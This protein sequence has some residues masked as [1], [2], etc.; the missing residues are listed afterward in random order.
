MKKIHSVN[1][2][3][4]TKFLVSELKKITKVNES[5]QVQFE[6]FYFLNSVSGGN[7]I[8][9]LNELKQ[10]SKNDSFVDSLKQ[11]IDFFNAKKIPFP[12]WTYGIF[13]CLKVL[14]IASDSVNYID[15]LSLEYSNL[16]KQ[17]SSVS[18]SKGGYFYSPNDLQVQNNVLIKYSGSSPIF[19]IPRFIDTIGDDAFKDNHHLTKVI[20][21]SH[22]KEIGKFAF[23]NCKALKTIKI[24]DLITT[25]QKGTFQGCSLLAKV[26]AKKI[27]TIEDHAFYETAIEAQPL[28]MLNLKNIGSYAFGKTQTK[29]RILL[30]PSIQRIGQY[31]FEQCFQVNE[32]SILSQNIQLLRFSNLFDKPEEFNAKY[33]VSTIELA[34]TRYPDGF[35]SNLQKIVSIALPNLTELSEGLFENNT[36]LISVTLPNKIDVIPDRLFKN[37]IKLSKIVVNDLIL[38]RIGTSAFE[39]CSSLKSIP[40]LSVEIIQDR[41]FYGSAI[42]NIDSFISSAKSLGD[43]CIGAIKF[44][45]LNLPFVGSKEKEQDPIKNKFGYIFSKSEFPQ[46]IDFIQHLNLNQK[47]S[48]KRFI[49]KGLN[50]ISFKI[51][52]L[53]EFSCSNIPE[54]SVFRL[55]ETT[56]NLPDFTFYQCPDL[57]EF[58]IPK[59]C[60]FFDGKVVD[61][62]PKLSI[63]SCDPSSKK[64]IS[65]DGVLF[66]K[67]MTELIF[68]PFNYSEKIFRVPPTVM[69]IKSRAFSRVRSLE[70]IILDSSVEVIE[71]EAIYHCEKLARIKLPS[72]IKIIAENAISFC[73]ELTTVNLYS[74]SFF[75]QSGIIIGCQQ[76]K[77]LHV[78]FQNTNNADFKFFRIFSKTKSD[79]TYEFNGHYIPLS[80]TQLIVLEGI[81]GAFAFEGM[82][83]IQNVE[84]KDKVKTIEPFAFKGILLDSLVIPDSVKS[85]NEKAF[86]DLKVKTLS[87]PYLG[88]DDQQP[89]PLSSI[90][91]F[92]DL[93]TISIRSGI[94][95]D[96][97]FSSFSSLQQIEIQ[98]VTT[99]RQQVFLGCLNIKKILIPKSVTKIERGAFEGSSIDILAVEDQHPIYQ[100]VDQTLV[101]NRTLIYY[102]PNKKDSIYNVPLTIDVI[103]K[104]S[105]QNNQHLKKIVF[106]NHVKQVEPQA[107]MDCI[108]LE[109]IELL[110]DKVSTISSYFKGTLPKIKSIKVLSSVIPHSA[111]AGLITLQK[112]EFGSKLEIIGDFAFADC[113][114]LLIIKIPETVTLIGDFAFKNCK[115]ITTIFVPDSVEKI[116]FG[117]FSGCVHLNTLTLPMRPKYVA[118]EL[119]MYGGTFGSLFGTFEYEHGR[120]VEQK[121]NHTTKRTYY[122]PK[123]LTAVRVTGGMMALG[124]FSGMSF[125][126]ELLVE[127]IQGDIGA[128]AFESCFALKSIVLNPSTKTIGKEAFKDCQELFNF[129]SGD[130]LCVIETGAFSGCQKLTKI[131]FGKGLSSIETNIFEDCDSLSEI[132]FTQGNPR[133]R[134][135]DGCLMDETEKSVILNPTKNPNEIVNIPETIETISSRAF[136]QSEKLREVNFSKNLKNIGNESFYS[137]KKLQEVNLQVCDQLTKIGQEAFAYCTSLKTINFNDQLQVIEPRCFNQCNNLEFINLPKSIVSIGQAIL[138]GCYSISAIK[139][140][141]LGADRNSSE[142]KLNYLFFDQSQSAPS[143]KDIHSFALL[144]A[145]EIFE[146]NISKEAFINFK[147]LKYVMLPISIQEILPS[148]FESC[149]NL[150]G[151][152]NLM[153]VRKIHD[154]GFY[155]CRNL[156]LSFNQLPVLES[157]GVS[158]FENCQNIT[159][160]K[161]PESLITLSKASFKNCQ[162]ITNIHIPEKITSIPT[163]AFAQLSKLNQVTLSDSINQIDTKAFE[164]CINLRSIFIPK[165]VK[166]IQ[167][168]AFLG[169]KRLVIEVEDMQQIKFFPQGWNNARYLANDITSLLGRLVASIGS[170]TLKV[171]EKKKVIQ[172]ESK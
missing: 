52:N 67:K 169:C 167:K 158:A 61:E 65:K 48:L 132:N 62:C 41:A 96:L 22:V 31:I 140:P 29:G 151:V 154:R 110:T 71:T 104:D 64:F 58:S 91:N 34:G 142:A 106:T 157:I 8:K 156:K 166:A 88:L 137:C 90:M 44:S 78:H 164:G 163:E 144:N 97:A 5:E 33:N 115:S 20:I 10:N 72:T 55:P 127:N 120:A 145:I 160:I 50:Q 21:P 118:T 95:H 111:F 170:S 36:T 108:N 25:I 79:Q 77:S 92:P 56:L 102:F 134:V 12:I 133:Y 94:L 15:P 128:Y 155:Q 16:F 171:T 45:A 9:E 124:A 86:F 93:S 38:R 109:S 81:I 37:C 122:F 3:T 103:A 46:S 51:G 13:V 84:I 117:V 57:Q 149:L 141:F 139:T 42:T 87:I 26:D 161:L 17:I 138:Q 105:I 23:S 59:D 70:E 172:H 30:G 69:V 143:I 35:F 99:I 126:K 113:E 63:I 49:P 76:L 11:K 114:S 47:M 80:L 148:T 131:Q 101:E 2:L 123:N 39:N 4:D 19:I 152:V 165:H 27:E 28:L 60:E 168:Y 40:I 7:L 125:L 14:D 53:T 89:T 147:S 136:Y 162:N 43:E 1:K 150:Q 68:L 66:D 74:S 82:N 116:G 98:G 100:V 119:S 107:I 75:H 135:V 73:Q 146:G 24:P 18:N 85:I 54:V 112:I 6:L 32:V 159:G 130:D 129:Q 153:S 121:I 83:S